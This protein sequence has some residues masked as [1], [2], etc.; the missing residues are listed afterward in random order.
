MG[1]FYLQV[2]AMTRASMMVRYRQSFAGFVWVLINPILMFVVQSLIFRNVLKFELQDFYLF[3]MSALLPWLFV[4]STLEMTV[5]G[6]V[7]NARMIKA[8]NFNPL[9]IV[10]AQVMD[11]FINLCISMALIL[12]VLCFFQHVSPLGVVLAMPGILILGVGISAMAI[13]LSVFQV[14]FRDLR[15]IVTFA[16][17]L[18]FFVTPIFYPESYLPTALRWLPHFN[19]AYIFIRPVRLALMGAE[20]HLWLSALLTALLCTMVFSLLAFWAWRQNEGQ[21]ILSI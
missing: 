8:Y 12:S 19:P 4:A 2:W 15:F 10:L 14:F 16:L 3:L 18:G 13:L 1:T 11:N 6:I 20:I 9:V 5:G 7:N 17:N 21:V